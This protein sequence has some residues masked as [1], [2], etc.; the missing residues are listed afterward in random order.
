MHHLIENIIQKRSTGNP[1]IVLNASDF[2][3]HETDRST[4]D[5]HVMASMLHARSTPRVLREY[6]ESVICTQPY[7]D[8]LMPPKF[9]S[10]EILCGS[11]PWPWNMKTYPWFLRASTTCT[12]IDSP[13]FHQSW[14]ISSRCN[15]SLQKAIMAASGIFDPAHQL[16]Y[17]P[18]V[19]TSFCILPNHPSNPTIMDCML[20]PPPTRSSSID[21]AIPL[22]ALPECVTAMIIF[23]PPSIPGCTG[24]GGSIDVKL[25]PSR[26]VHRIQSNHN[27]RDSGGGGGFIIVPNNSSQ[28]LEPPQRIASITHAHPTGSAGMIVG[29]YV[30]YV[31]RDRALD[32]SNIRTCTFRSL[33]TGFLNELA[34]HIFAADRGLPPAV[35]SYDHFY[36]RYSWLPSQWE[37]NGRRYARLMRT[38]KSE[39]LVSDGDSTNS[40]NHPSTLL[41]TSAAGIAVNR[42]PYVFKPWKAGDWKI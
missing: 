35:S 23:P 26:Q 7:R 31:R 1:Y 3:E 11:Q 19:E 12:P 4:S 29:C 33:R 8:D 15:A 17:A 40:P 14:M 27:G 24:G 30:C 21:G 5:A 41:G 34:M 20:P 42:S 6:W 28:C 38:L 13:A 39:R 32:A 36:T 37:T 16:Q 2:F 25:I 18:C 10:D 22:T 9:P